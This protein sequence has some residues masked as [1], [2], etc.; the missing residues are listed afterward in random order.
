MH[1]L[2]SVSSKQVITI[3]HKKHLKVKPASTGLDV[4]L[5]FNLDEM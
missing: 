4:N 2:I 1:V 3:A 5:I